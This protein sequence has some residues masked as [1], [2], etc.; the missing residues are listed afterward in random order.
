MCAQC[1]RAALPAAAGVLVTLCTAAAP[2]A[3]GAW[4]P[5][6]R[7]APAPTPAR[8]P[9]LAALALLYAECCERLCDAEAILYLSDVLVAFALGECG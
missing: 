1:G 7:A 8:G 2:F 4:M 6:P 9:Q 5:R 3:A